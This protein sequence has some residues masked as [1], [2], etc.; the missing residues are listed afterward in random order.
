MRTITTD[1][2]PAPVLGLVLLEQGSPVLA[3]VRPGCRDGFVDEL[4]DAAGTG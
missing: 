2:L 1:D 4:V 3:L